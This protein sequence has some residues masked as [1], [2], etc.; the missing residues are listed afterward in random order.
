MIQI[1]DKT[2]CSGCEACA[3]ICPTQCI[4]M[5]DD[6]EGFPYPVADPHRCIHCGLC[7]RVCPFLNKPEVNDESTEWVAAVN[8]DTETVR[9]SSSGGIFSALAHDTLSRCGEVCGAGFNM[10]FSEVCHRWASTTDEIEG[11]IGSKY[12]QSRVGES[13][14]DVREKLKAGLPVLFVGTPCQTAGLKN[15]LQGK[16]YPRLLLVDVLCHGVPSP[17]VWRRY[18]SERIDSLISANPGLADHAVDAVSFRDKRNG[19]EDYSVTVC[20]SAR[21][22]DGAIVHNRQ[23]INNA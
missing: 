13:F 23:S 18:L 7:E 2:L 1:T 11:L 9:K 5:V 4:D 3:Q 15:F 22:R 12:V 20:I 8:N 19:W 10:D 17:Q 14:S 21:D 16:S 6:S